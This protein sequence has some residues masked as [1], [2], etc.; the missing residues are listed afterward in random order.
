MEVHLAEPGQLPVGVEPAAADGG[1][2]VVD[3]AGVD[4]V[5]VVDAVTERARLEER[6]GAEDVAAQELHLVVADVPERLV[7]RLEVEQV[8]ARPSRAW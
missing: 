8:V 4:P 7:R 3:P 6:V 1:R 2:Q 5:A